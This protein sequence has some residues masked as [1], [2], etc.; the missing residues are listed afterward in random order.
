TA[1]RNGYGRN[2]HADVR[3]QRGGSHHRHHQTEGHV[4]QRG[5]QAVA[6]AVR[7][8]DLAAHHAGECGGGA[9]RS[10]AGRAER[11]VN[12]LGEGGQDDHKT[13]ER[14]EIYGMNFS[15]TFILRP[16][17]TSLIMAAIALFGVISYRAHPVSDMPQIDYPTLTVM[18]GLPGANPD[19]MASAVA[20][21]L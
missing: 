10:R 7:A 17:A 6:R 14:R 21:P 9:E 11:T 12:L 8:C 20:T 18:A 13:Q 15:E 16:I 4:H 2:R 5:P 1:G 19:T 3:G